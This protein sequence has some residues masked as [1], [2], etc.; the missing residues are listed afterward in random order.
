MPCSLGE[1]FDLRV[2]LQILRRDILNVVIDGEYRLRWI[3]DLRRADLLKLWN[4]RAGVVM[5]H[6]MARPNRDEIARAHDRLRGSPSACRAAI[7]STSVRP[8]S[9]S[10]IVRFLHPIKTFKQLLSLLRF[11]ITPVAATPLPFRRRYSNISAPITKRSS[12][13]QRHQ[14]IAHHSLD[15]R[16]RISHSRHSCSN[17][18]LGTFSSSSQLVSRQLLHVTS[19]RRACQEASRYRS[20]RNQR[21]ER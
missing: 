8:I 10:S 3:R 19:W 9:I 12:P 7:F 15:S 21:D 20:P 14:F 13:E 1:R 17:L 4:H 16:R 11:P 5:R 18:S 6:H 2:L